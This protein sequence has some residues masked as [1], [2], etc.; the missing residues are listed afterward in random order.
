MLLSGGTAICTRVLK[1][2]CFRSLSLGSGLCFGGLG[3]VRND[4]G[5]L[6]EEENFGIE[7]GL[8]L[9]LTV[10][11]T[12][13][14]QQVPVESPCNHLL[15]RRSRLHSP[16]GRKGP[17]KESVGYREG[18]EKARDSTRTGSSDG[19]FDEEERISKGRSRGRNRKGRR[20]TGVFG[21]QSLKVGG[22]S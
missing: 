3:H 12:R 5:Q 14:G 22:G 19:T 9:W 17:R 15:K 13:G 4:G 16:L 21:H 6:W 18:G 8:Q 20:G 1:K 11:G 2:R 10:D 7:K